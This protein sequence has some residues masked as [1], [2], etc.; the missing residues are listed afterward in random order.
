MAINFH[1]IACLWVAI[2]KKRQGIALYTLQDM[3]LHFKIL[4]HMLIPNISDH[5]TQSQVKFSERC[6]AL[7]FAAGRLVR[8]TYYVTMWRQIC[9]DGK[10][11]DYY[12]RRRFHFNWKFVPWNHQIKDI[13]SPQSYSNTRNMVKNNTTWRLKNNTTVAHGQ[14]EFKYR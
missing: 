8:A 11:W 9:V 10:E 3:I 12:G 13:C 1:N 7:D 6:F 14:L 2:S 4:P 5:Y